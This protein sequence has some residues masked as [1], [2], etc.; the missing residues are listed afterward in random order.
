MKFESSN[1]LVASSDYYYRARYYDPATGRFLNED[2]IGFDGG[3][4]FYPYVQNDSQDWGDFEGTQRDRRTT[5]RPDGTD[6][7]FKKLKPDPDDP[8]KVIY[9]DPN[10]GKETKKAKP[11]GFDDYWKKKHPPR[12]KP[13]Q[14]PAKP[15]EGPEPSKS[16]P[17]EPEPFQWPPCTPFSQ[18]DYCAPNYNPKPSPFFPWIPPVPSPALGP[19]GLPDLLPFPA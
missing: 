3:I 12:P 7:P 17:V 19:V 5:G 8:S 14:C 6:N 15:D 1:E 16:V 2:P 18:W 10:T 11:P 9:K 13:K 4:D